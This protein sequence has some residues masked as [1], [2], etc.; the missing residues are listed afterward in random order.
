MGLPSVNREG[1]RYASAVLRGRYMHLSCV[2]G[3][4]TDIT[5]VSKD[6]LALREEPRRR[7]RAA[8]AAHCTAPCAPCPSPRADSRRPSHAACVERSDARVQPCGRVRRGVRRGREEGRRRATGRTTSRLEDAIGTRGVCAR[9]QRCACSSREPGEGCS[10]CARC[11]GEEVLYVVSRE[12]KLVA[13]AR[14]ARL[15]TM[16]PK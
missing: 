2:V 1:S 10:G 3:A 14:G 16:L 12:R 9:S 8:Q 11:G 6:L 5:S 13:L 4:L 15:M 7:A